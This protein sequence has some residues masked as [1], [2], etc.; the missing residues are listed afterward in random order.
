MRCD[1]S[2]QIAVR[3][4][5]DRE[6]QRLVHDTHR[7]SD[8][9]SPTYDF[10]PAYWVLSELLEEVT[11][12]QWVTTKNLRALIR[13]RLLEEAF[14]HDAGDAVVDPHYQ[15]KLDFQ[16]QLVVEVLEKVHERSL[17]TT[18]PHTSRMTDMAGAVV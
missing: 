12:S 16:V 11:S 13:E 9:I 2:M 15:L 3:E 4:L 17:L 10:Q 7:S 14:L 1:T 6:C 5:F 18:Y 8:G